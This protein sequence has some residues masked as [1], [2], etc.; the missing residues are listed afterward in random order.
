M[1]E[2][3]RREQRL[4]RSSDFV[5]CYRR[6]TRKHGYFASVHFHANGSQDSRLGITAS[7]KVGK[8][9]IRHKLKRRAREIFRRFRM[10]DRLS[11]LDVVVHLKPTAATC[12]FG[13][14]RGELERLFRLAGDAARKPQ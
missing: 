3:L 9:V 4:R 11:G 12:E 14:F 7:R 8:A 6:G 13:T 10:R 5:R 2:G 1:C